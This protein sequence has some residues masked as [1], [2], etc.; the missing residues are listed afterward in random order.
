MR[1]ASREHWR[2]LPTG[3]ATWLSAQTQSQANLIINMRH[4]D[5]IVEHEP[6]DL[7]AIA[8]AGVTLADFNAKLRENGQWLPLDP[9]DDGRA[10]I[11]GVVATGIGG[12][13]QIGC[14]KP[15][16][17]VIGMKDGRVDGRG[18]KLGG[19]VVVEDDS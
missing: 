3:G 9:P 14:G 4:L 16:G 8:Q 15:R 1:L 5:E 6:S 12:A 11:G 7:I 13:Q 19:R 18:T 2:V 10:T 17:A